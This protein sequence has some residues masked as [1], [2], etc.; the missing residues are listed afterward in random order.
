MLMR[1]ILLRRFDPHLSALMSID[2]HLTKH[3]STHPIPYS[4]KGV[5]FHILFQAT[6]PLESYLDSPTQG[7]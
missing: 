5:G 6:P 3:A 4:T 2:L 7:I 1:S